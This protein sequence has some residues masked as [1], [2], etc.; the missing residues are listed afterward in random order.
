VYASKISYA[1][2]QHNAVYLLNDNVKQFK[3]VTKGQYNE[4]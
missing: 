4:K 1:S 2:L 3:I